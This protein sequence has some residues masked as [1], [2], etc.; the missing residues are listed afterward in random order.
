MSTDCKVCSVATA[1]RYHW[2]LQSPSSKCCRETIVTIL[3]QHDEKMNKDDATKEYSTGFVCRVCF[4][5]V[6]KYQ[7]IR[8]K[9]AELENGLVTKLTNATASMRSKDALSTQESRGVEA[10]A[11]CGQPVC[12]VKDK[13]DFRHLETSARLINPE[14][15][16]MNPFLPSAATV[17]ANVPLGVFL[18]N[19]NK[20][21]EM[22]DILD[23][24]HN[25]ILLGVTNSQLPGFVGATE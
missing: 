22:A 23:H 18:K 20:L 16:D 9:F 3:S 8:K 17:S 25:H 13:I 19:E 21:D 6:K 5:T 15:L 12:K 2:E 14:V 7:A 11:A 4:S 10:V 1:S 24:L